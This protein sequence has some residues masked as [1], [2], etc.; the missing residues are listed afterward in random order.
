MKRSPYTPTA[1]INL[2]HICGNHRQLCETLA[3]NGQRPG[4]T[5]PVPDR[6]GTPAPFTWPAIMPV[7]KSDAYG[8]G[9]I[10]V[11]HALLER[12]GVHA[13][14]SGRV[15]EAV[16]LRQ[17]LDELAV[18]K[19]QAQRENFPLILSLVGP[20]GPEDVA[21]CL[22][23]NIVPVIHTREQ[24]PLLESLEATLPVA[25]KCNSGMARLGFGPDEM[26]LVIERLRSL[27]NVVP[28]LALSHL[29]NA[30]SDEGAAN[31]RTQAGVFAE[32]LSALREVWPNI[33][34]SL[35]NSAG[36][37]QVRIATEIIGQHTCRSGLSLYGGNPLHDTGLAALGKGLKPAMAVSA[38][39]MAVRT[40]MPGE[41]TGYGH[42]FVACEKMR[43]GIVSVGYADHLPRGL[44]NR[45]FFCAG[46]VRVRVLGRVSME[47][48]AVD[49]SDVPD[50]G[51]G[52]KVWLIGGPYEAAMT[53]EEQ[54]ATLGTI[55]YEVLCLLGANTRV[56]D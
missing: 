55:S 42:A 21:L 20:M 2:D 7:V 8:H 10:R 16:D 24:L 49:L 4:P 45:G 32:M 44:S 51:V 40:L 30:D 26:D 43:I 36:M 18:Q 14:A 3:A 56:Y 6:G 25:V 1:H 50:I 11:A 12:E 38:P 22:E 29:A 34:A 13:F 15:Q 39:I 37:L 52:D 28:V 27:P 19:G 33:A 48:T 9:G 5:V 23:F 54:A 46:G 47:M 35:C 41:G 53:P 31:I 17:G